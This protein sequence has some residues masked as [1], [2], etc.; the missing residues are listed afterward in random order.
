MLKKIIIHPSMMSKK[1]PPQHMF[2][3][4]WNIIN[5]S[6][7]MQHQDKTFATCV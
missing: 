4:A 1:K 5:L 2:H 3:V 7:K 6:I